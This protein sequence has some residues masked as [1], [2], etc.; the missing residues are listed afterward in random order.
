MSARGRT[1]RD[2]PRT[3]VAAFEFYPTPREAVLALIDSPLILLPGGRWIEPCAGTGRINSTVNSRRGDVSWWLCEI[4]ERHMGAL[5]DSLRVS[6]GP[7]DEDADLLLP[8]G[9]FVHR[10]WSFA[11]ADVCIMNPPFSHALAFVE[12]AMQ[13]ARNVVMLQRSTWFAPARCA[14]LRKHAP[15]VYMLPARPSFTGDGSTDATE[16]AWFVW[17]DGEHD[18]RTGNVSMLDDVSAAVQPMLIGDAA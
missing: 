1:K 11:R 13:R 5:S 17:P 2:A 8:F 9:D 15:D 10:E 14:W 4:D 12:A 3:E 7:D 6:D 18:R 16:Y